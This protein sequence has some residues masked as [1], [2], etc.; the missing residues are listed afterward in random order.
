MKA[1]TVAPWLGW[2]VAGALVAYG[3]MNKARGSSPSAPPAAAPAPPAAGFLADAEGDE[4]LPQPSV[5]PSIRAALLALAVHAP[6]IPTDPAPILSALANLEPSPAPSPSSSAAS[7]PVVET[8]SSMDVEARKMAAMTPVLEQMAGN[9]RRLKE[10]QADYAKSC[11][12]STAV[13]YRDAY[14]S[15]VQGRLDNAD[16]PECV[17]L[18]TEM[19]GLKSGLERKGAEVQDAAR[20]DGVLPGVMRRL[21]EQYRLQPYLKP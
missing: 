9:A 5:D 15:Q 13:P 20:R 18:K 14:G 17:A 10:A 21:A 19:S 2:L 3:A 4:P 11:V 16:L 8:W 7:S 6:E 12:G 1:R